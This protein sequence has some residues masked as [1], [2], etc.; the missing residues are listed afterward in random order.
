MKKLIITLLFIII[1][2]ILCAEKSNV[3]F[4]YGV[5]G[6]QTSNSDS[7]FLFT[8]ASELM[9]GNEIKLNFEYQKG[10]YLY[11]L[12]LTADNEFCLLFSSVSQQNLS[13]ED[14][15]FTS[16]PWM[17]IEDEKNKGTLYIISALKQL[18]S[19]EKNIKNYSDAKE[20]NKVKFH[21]KILNEISNY[22]IGITDKKTESLVKRLE[23]PIIG[24]I[25]FRYIP[26]FSSNLPFMTEQK[27]THECKGINIAVAEIRLF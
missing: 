13:E 7:L 8:E 3:T 9:I 25:T 23:K 17:R 5:I 26:K 1:Y 19:L 22:N 16:L 21:K 24:G 27:M 18:K 10:R 2:L 4:K 11:V 20:K 15:I 12:S 6:K 14:E